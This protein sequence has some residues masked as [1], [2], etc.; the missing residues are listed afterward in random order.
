MAAATDKGMFDKLGPAITDVLVVGAGA[1]AGGWLGMMVGSYVPGVPE[2]LLVGLGA[3]IVGGTSRSIKE[4]VTTGNYTFTTEA[5]T[6]LAVGLLSA[7]MA[8]SNFDVP[9]LGPSPLAHGLVAGA[10]AGWFV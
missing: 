3:G 6:G 1:T 9:I 2:W 5:N 10:V 4:A 8:Y 7:L